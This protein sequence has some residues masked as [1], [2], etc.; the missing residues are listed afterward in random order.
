[1]HQRGE[2]ID[3]VDVRTPAEFRAVHVT[4]ARNVPLEK[5][6]LAAVRNGSSTQPLYVIC[7]SGARGT[8]ACEKLIAAGGDHVVNVIGGTKAWV[9]ADLPVVRG[10]KIIPLDRQV[11]IAAGSMVMAGTLI[12]YFV[13]PWLIGL[14]AFVGAGLIYAGITDYCPLATFLARMPWNQVSGQVSS[15]GIKSCTTA[16]QCCQAD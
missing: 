5:C 16:V 7:Q 15:S 12:G 11:R 6:D 4:L 3:L 8:K 2:A 13:Y 1:L 14:A 10:K 9:E